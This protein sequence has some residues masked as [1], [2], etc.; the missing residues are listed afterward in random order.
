MIKSNEIPIKHAQSIKGDI[1]TTK[2]GKFNFYIWDYTGVEHFSFIWEEFIKESDAVLLITDSTKENIE[3]SKFF[4]EIIRSEAP[5]ANVAVIANKQDLIQ[6]MNAKEIEKILGFKTYSI[7]AV[8]PINR[9]KIIQ[10]IAEL[11]N[12]SSGVSQQIR[13][14][15]ERDN[16][17]NYLEQLIEDNDFQLA[18]TVID[19]II[20]LCVELGDDALS[21]DFKELGI[22]LDHILDEKINDIGQLIPEGLTETEPAEG[23]ATSVKA[24]LLETLVT[25]YMKSIE[26]VIE[27]TICDRDGF[28]IMSQS[29]K[30]IAR[31]DVLGAMAT[32]I[33]D[34]IDRMKN[35][36]DAEGNF[37]NITMISDKKI[38][39]CSMGPNSILTSIAE[40]S[41]SDVE[42][43]IF[44]E[45]VAS[46]VEL[47][48]EGNENVDVEIPLVITTMSKSKGGELP[49]GKFSTKIIMTGNYQVGKTSLVSRFVRNL[50]QE[51]YQSTIGV[52]LSEKVVE[53]SDDT[54]IKF[55]IWDIGGQIT[56]I[57]PY[58][59]RFYEGANS[60]FI[61]L[62]RTRP[63][64]L[65]SV[66]I[67]YN[68]I[69]KY[70]NEDIN[71]II[72]GN[73][74]DLTDE[75]KVSEEDIR[76][77][78]EKFGFHYILTSAKTGENVN[79]AFLYIAYKFLESISS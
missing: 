65:K 48:L 76:S 13:T 52:D 4:L 22:K 33:D 62:D 64:T 53:L 71:I 69:S 10:I 66:E 41:A 14:M 25:N 3:K 79:D 56:Q 51:S 36:F 78:A 8:D 32:V 20:D 11:L 74:T 29:K 28:T 34:Y 1:A 46:K 31:D 49:T 40:L 16:L 70:V 73:K 44:S 38:A 58:R 17:R 37:F 12:I 47:I 27:V 21:N 75:I 24:R 7:V 43:R 61:V 23:Q 9:I 5:I 54:K 68:D 39:Y 30:K 42:L 6:A 59:K 60:A 35:E 57:A 77:L 15:E 72:V 2:I 50:F 26:S 18:N 55:I 63:G 45:H 67:W 19:R